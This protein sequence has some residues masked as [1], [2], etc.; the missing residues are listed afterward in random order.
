[1]IKCVFLLRRQPHLTREAFLAYW[2]NQ[3]AKLAKEV[4]GP[5]RM[6]RYI[7]LHPLDHPMGGMLA[8][9]RGSK[10]AD[11]DGI[12]ECWWNSFEDMSEVAG[13]ADELA[14]KVLADEMSFVDLSRSEMMFVEE[15]IVIS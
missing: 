9:S 1:M 2:R 14:A 5:M 10:V 6:R 11:W 4:A 13:T 8:Q 3:H 15:N 7:Q 12:T